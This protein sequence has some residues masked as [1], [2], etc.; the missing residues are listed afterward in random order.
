LFNFDVGV[1][2]VEE[3]AL[4]A[5]QRQQGRRFPLT[6]GALKKRQRPAVY[7]PEY[8]ASSAALVSAA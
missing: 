3:R 5:R 6:A 1:F 2:I 8:A 7:L 4:S